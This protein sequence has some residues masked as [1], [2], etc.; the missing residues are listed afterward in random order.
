[1]TRSHVMIASAII[2]FHLA[3]ES[4]GFVAPVMMKPQQTRWLTAQLFSSPSAESDPQQQQEPPKEI[5]KP[6]ILLPFLPAADPK[7][8]VR[9]PVGDGDFIC[10]RSGGP[11]ADELSNENIIKIVRIECS[12]LEVGTQQLS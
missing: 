12:D 11:T 6:D 10:T 5:V 3:M 4:N 2:I 7:Y 8:S 1:M 9:G